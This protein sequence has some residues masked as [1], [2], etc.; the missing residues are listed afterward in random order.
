[1]SIFFSFF[2]HPS[3][4]HHTHTLLMLAKDTKPAAAKIA[5][6][7]TGKTK[8]VAK[9]AHGRARGEQADEGATM[10]AS[11]KRREKKK[12]AKKA[13]VE[14]KASGEAPPKP[15]N[16]GVLYL[17]EWATKDDDGST[18]K[19]QKVRQ[20][21][22]L[23]NMFNPASVRREEPCIFFLLNPEQCLN[24]FILAPRTT[25]LLSVAAQH[26]VTPSSRMPGRA[27]QLSNAR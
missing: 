20:T 8:A 4:P 2:S 14:A 3:P 15:T 1:M 22:L 6:L 25:Q 11:K 13:R 19:F 12:A 10:T 18:W 17:R 7:G 16:V 23:K 26:A 21:W 5:V 24:V 9:V 27:R